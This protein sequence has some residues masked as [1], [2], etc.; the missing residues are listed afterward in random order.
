MTVATHCGQDTLATGTLELCVTAVL[1]V[2]I[3]KREANEV[4]KIT[5]MQ[6]KLNAG[7]TLVCP[8]TTFG[9]ITAIRAV[10]FPITEEATRNAAG[11]V[12]ALMRTALHVLCAFRFIRAVLT[13][14]HTITHLSLLNAHPSM[15]TLELVYR[16]QI[17]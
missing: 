1:L 10:T 2:Y 5:H 15:G 8:H 14:R 7:R 11:F 12:V 3:D 16:G 13:V 17:V 4:L 9:L 6:A